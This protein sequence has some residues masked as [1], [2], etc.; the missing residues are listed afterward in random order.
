[1]AAP[2]E[3]PADVEEAS[4]RRPGPRRRL[5]WDIAP[6]ATLTQGPEGQLDEAL[7]PHPGGLADLTSWKRRDSRRPSVGGSS[8]GR[9]RRIV[10]LGRNSG[11]PRDCLIERLEDREALVDAGH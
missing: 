6:D 4:P 11:K 9:S 7:L 2:K 8:R 10:D 1:M 3:T 5:G